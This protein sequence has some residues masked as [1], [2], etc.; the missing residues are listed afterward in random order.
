V[1]DLVAREGSST[2]ETTGGLVIWG[3]GPARAARGRL[4]EGAAVVSWPG[5]DVSRLQRAGVPFRAVE[6][7]LGAEGLAAADGAARGWARVWGRL[8]LLDGKS[9]RELVPWRGN[10][11]LWNASTFLVEKTAGPRCARMADLALRL[12]ET[13]APS[14]VDAPGLGPAEA[15]LLG[16]ACRAR[17]VLFHGPVPASGRPLATAVPRGGPWRKLAVLLAPSAAPPLP[18]PAA[19]V[20][21][22]A[23]PVVV[24]VAGAEEGRAV[25]PLLRAISADL[26]RSVVPVTL[27]ELSRWETRRVHRAVSEAGAFLR[28]LFGRLRGTPGLAESYSHRGV[29]F[30][31]LAARDLEALLLGHLPGA[32]RWI[33][34]AVELFTSTG[35]AAVLLAVPGPDE[36]RAFVHACAASG[37]G[38]IVLRLGAPAEG[39]TTRADGGPQPLAALDWRPGE[40]P[41]PVVARLREAVHG[42]V[43]AG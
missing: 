24:L 18:S 32:V 2:P 20:G 13:T 17:G 36:R 43:G 12:L 7:L 8:P 21:L 39:D 40:D 10:S 9:F 35:A 6:S 29:G 37:V 23:P 27:A 3:G 22:T 11:L 30:A 41:E 34:A 5:A 4:R 42:R 1:L 31:D 15:L 16:R 38:T 25:A 19:G 14:E 28:A 33:E 26:W